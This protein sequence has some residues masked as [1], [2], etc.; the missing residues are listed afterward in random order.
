MVAALALFAC[1]TP[2]PPPSS[3]ATRISLE[4]GPC[5]G[6]CPIYKVEIKGDGSVTYTGE[7]FVKITGEQHAQISREE[8][9]ALVAKFE[10]ADFFSLKDEYTAPVTDLPTY[11]LSVSFSGRNKTVTDYG[12]RMADMPAV[13]TEL[14]NEVDRVAGT[15]QWVKGGE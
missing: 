14:E 6:T 5:F 7:R 1:S 12:G 3:D 11:T 10:K 2:K 13:V 4:R 8:V 9:S 15:D